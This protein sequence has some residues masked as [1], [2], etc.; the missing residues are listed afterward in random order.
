MEE[1][2]QE[3]ATF[4]AIFQGELSPVVQRD[5]TAV[6]TTCQSCKQF[7]QSKYN[8]THDSHLNV[9]GDLIL[10]MD[11]QDIWNLVSSHV[12]IVKINND[13]SGSCYFIHC[14]YFSEKLW[15]CR[16]VVQ[17]PLTECPMAFQT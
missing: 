3:E 12:L 11:F 9:D 6:V 15:I 10:R 17:L 4:T 1:L 14:Q 13:I 16:A 7:T 5:Q 2:H 8:I